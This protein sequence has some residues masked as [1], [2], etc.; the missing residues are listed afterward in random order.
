MP[1]INLGGGRG[2]VEIP[3]VTIE[4]YTYNGSSHGPAITYAAGTS[5]KITATGTSA[6][7]AGT[8]TL[9]LSLNDPSR[10]TWSD[11]TIA[12]KTYQYTIS[13]LVITKP[14]VSV[15][16]YTYNGNAQGPTVSRDTTN[17]NISGATGTNAGNYALTISLKN[18][19]SMVWSDTNTSA[20]K[21]YAYTIKQ[22]TPTLTLSKTSVTLNNS[23]TSVAVT[24]TRSGS[25]S[26]SA[27]SSNTSVST[28]TV[29]GTTITVKSVNSKSGSATITVTLAATTNYTSKT[30]T[31][32]VTASFVT[33]V[34]WASGTDAQV[35]AMIDAAR[36]GQ[37]KLSDHWKVGDVRNISL[38]AGSATTA[39]KTT[40]YNWST[41]TVGIVITSFS[42]YEGCGNLLQF[43]FANLIEPEGSYSPLNYRNSP[44]YK[45][46]YACLYI[47]PAIANS[48]PSWIKS[49]LKTFSCKAKSFTSSAAIDTITGNK[50]ALR[51]EIEVF[52]STAHS[53]AGEGSHVNYYN[54]A[55]RRKKYYYDEGFSSIWWLRSAASRDI[56]CAVF[57]KYSGGTEATVGGQYY[58]QNYGLAPFGCL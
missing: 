30:A 14:T 31:I 47:M 9:T 53:T 54:S 18:T 42:N 5:D 46:S 40:C 45:D 17:T 32:S 51:S 43:D 39:N 27:S 13:P 36:A 33:I 2:I 56:Y 57:G 52:N 28:A 12:D 4:T 16:T 55:D 21:T 24:A 22:A 6:V 34:S 15:G 26:L 44:G 1:I 3:T 58:T 35:A 20:N 23:T 38:S 50:L 49:R 10:Y 25:G 7:E 37:I 29:S 11:R 19:T 8:Y 41:Q 48:M